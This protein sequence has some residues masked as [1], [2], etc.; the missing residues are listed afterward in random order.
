VARACRTGSNDVW[1]NVLTS[2]LSRA[3]AVG[4]VGA[5]AIGGFTAAQL[6][7]AVDLSVDGQLTSMHVFGSTVAD[8]LG[9]AGIAVGD[10]DLVVPA[11]DQPIADGSAILVRYGRKVTVTVDGATADYWTTATTVDEAIAQ[12][13]IRTLAGAQISVS[14]SAGLGR[15]GLTFSVTNPHQVKVVADGQTRTESSSAA[16]VGDLLAS[17]GIT[18]GPLDRVSPAA[19]TAVTEGLAV[20]VAR[21]TEKTSTATEAVAFKTTKTNDPNLSKGQTK[22][23]T[24]GVAGSQV[25]TYTETWV[26]GVLESRKATG[27]TV[28]KP[29]VD[30][31]VVVGTKPLPVTPAPSAG[32]VSGAGIN[33]ANAAMWDRIAKCE[34]GGNWHIN[35]GNGYYGGLQF[36][37]TT[38]LSSG[39][40]DFAPRADLASREEQITVANRLYAVRGLQPWGCRWAA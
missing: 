12:L 40:A 11:A 32:N 8:A 25:V 15:E 4:A 35:T 16:S 6:D 29:A 37:Y 34:S 5:A 19:D 36:A 3:I 20:A 33:L 22:T 13:G 14:R 7:K 9:K 39:G 31:V 27:A 1:R 24:K 21:V 2:I 30:A 10:H 38:W 28:T 18:L 23:T 17:L 26:D